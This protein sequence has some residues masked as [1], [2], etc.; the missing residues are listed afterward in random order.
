MKKRNW[1]AILAFSLAFLV[2]VALVAYGLWLPTSIDFL[3]K[4]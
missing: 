2:V 1:K 3:N 4:Y